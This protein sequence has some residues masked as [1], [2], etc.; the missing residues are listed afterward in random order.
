MTTM[1]T[2][3]ERLPSNS[4]DRGSKAASEATTWSRFSKS[5]FTMARQ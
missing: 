5:P 4:T 3:A 2:D 1:T